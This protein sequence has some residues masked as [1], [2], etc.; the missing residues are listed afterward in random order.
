MIEADFHE[1]KA[2]HRGLMDLV[3]EVEPWI[4]SEILAGNKDTRELGF[5]VFRVLWEPIRSDL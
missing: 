2:E 3:L 5:Q 1:V 4:P